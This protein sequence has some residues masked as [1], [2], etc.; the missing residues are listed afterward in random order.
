MIARATGTV[1]KTTNTA[2]PRHRF[3]ESHSPGV[4]RRWKPVLICTERVTKDDL[5]GVRNY[6]KYMK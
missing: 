5:V 1:P 4:F 3:Y 2:N 6:D